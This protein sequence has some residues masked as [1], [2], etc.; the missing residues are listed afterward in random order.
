MGREGPRLSKAR[1]LGAEVRGP[2]ARS[3]STPARA[4]LHR[5]IPTSIPCRVAVRQRHRID[6]CRASRFLRFPASIRRGRCRRAI[7]ATTP[8]SNRWLSP[9]LESIER[10]SGNPCRRRRASA[11][12]ACRAS[13]IWC[14]PP[15]AVDRRFTELLA[16]LVG[17]QVELV[18]VGG[19][20][21]VRSGGPVA[22]PRASTAR[23]AGHGG[24]SPFADSPPAPSHVESRG[25]KSGAGRRRQRR[26][27]SDVEGT[28][29]PAISSAGR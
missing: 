6:S 26:R 28:G 25:R 1:G 24:R 5:G 18:V 9:P 27:G 2:S 14:L 22:A 11:S 19:V 10:S 23:F 3:P 13:S 15:A 21:A 12:R 4:G 7:P 17:S 8:G 20:R 16:L 29:S